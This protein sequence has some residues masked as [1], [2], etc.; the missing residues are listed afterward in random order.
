MNANLFLVVPFST[1][2]PSGS[3]QTPLLVCLHRPT[4]PSYFSPLPFHFP[5]VNPVVQIV[6]TCST[7]K[8]PLRL[9]V[10]FDPSIHPSILSNVGLSVC[11]FDVV[12]VFRL[13]SPQWCGASLSIGESPKKKKEPLDFVVAAADVVVVVECC[14]RSFRFLLLSLVGG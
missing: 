12:Q 10:W 4:D 14:S 8:A 6:V 3:D 2:F 1:L 13:D 9:P 5:L 7:F 11:L